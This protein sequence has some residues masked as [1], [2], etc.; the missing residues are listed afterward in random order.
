MVTMLYCLT[1]RYK[2][3]SES[4]SFVLSDF[5]CSFLLSFPHLYIYYSSCFHSVQLSCQIIYSKL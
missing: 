3:L 1:V 4:L 2:G 5:D